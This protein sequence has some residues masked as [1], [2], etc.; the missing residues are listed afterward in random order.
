MN[1]SIMQ[2]KKNNRIQAKMESITPEYAA[3]LI[4]GSQIFQNRPLSTLIVKKY[5]DIMRRGLWK[6][7]GEPIILDEDG[8]VLNGQHRLH[9]VIISGQSIDAMVVRG[10]DQQAFDSIDKGRLRSNGDVLAIAGYNQAPALA[11]AAS[12]LYRY[13][14]AGGIVSEGGAQRSRW[15]ADASLTLVKFVGLHPGLLDSMRFIRGH[16]KQTEGL[17]PPA[18][19]TALHYLFGLTAGDKRDGFFDEF[20]NNKGS[21]GDAVY[22]LI[23]AH[24]SRNVVLSMK[25]S[26]QIRA[27]YWIKSF[28]SYALGHNLIQLKWTPENNDFPK[29]VGLNMTTLVESAK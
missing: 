21:K 12:S 19:L 5:A 24:R 4:Q 17:S 25:S 26:D 14:R 28:N 11:A 29:I 20:I 27:A 9:A 22:A 3:Y 7:N 10:V 2:E 6:A 15:H 18:L 1:Q 13:I 8:S 16:G 23:Q